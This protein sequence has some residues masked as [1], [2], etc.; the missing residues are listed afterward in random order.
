MCLWIGQTNV[1]GCSGGTKGGAWGN[2]SA[3]V[4]PPP[5]LAPS[6]KKKMQTSAIFF[7]FLIFFPLRNTVRPLD[8]SYKK[9]W[10]RH[11][12]DVWL[13]E[14]ITRLFVWVEK[15]R[16][17]LYILMVPVCICLWC[18]VWP[19]I[20]Q[21]TVKV[22]THA[23]TRTQLQFSD[24]GKELQKEPTWHEPE[25]AYALVYFDSPFWNQYNSKNQSNMST[26]LEPLR[27]EWPQSENCDS[28]WGYYLFCGWKQRLSW[29]KNFVKR[30]SLK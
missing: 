13:L 8:A 19:H 15:D 26:Y 30:G 25:R 24:R 3:R 7:N 18:T 23:K 20:W 11:W 12:M 1:N 4:C 5:P 6:L 29:G 2:P 14:H 17:V 9:F 27:W 10:C 16:L 22:G 21:F 28:S